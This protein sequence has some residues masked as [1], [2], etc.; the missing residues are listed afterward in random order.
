MK[1]LFPLLLLLL[2]PPAAAGTVTCNLTLGAETVEGPCLYTPRKNGS[3]TA[4]MADGRSLGGAASVTLDLSGPSPRLSGKAADGS[5]R[6]WGIARR[7][8][9]DRACWVGADV[10]LCARA[11]E[12]AAQATDD[13]PVRFTGR[14]HMD[15][16]TWLRQSR[17]WPVAEGSAAVP[18]H[19]VA[20]ME[21][22][23][24]TEHRGADYPDTAPATARWD[25]PHEVRY[26]CSN[27]RPAVQFPDQ[28]WQV[29][30]LPQVFGATEAATAAYL[31]ACHRDAAGGDP[32]EAPA[33]LGYTAGQGSADSYPDFA[34]LIRK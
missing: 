19:A 14:C 2:A 13:L 33:R 25:Q 34:A 11:A 10:R 29:L 6:D 9:G 16:C 30:P 3:F 18:G 17:P 27:Q 21:S 26:F 5:I 12:D 22:M 4:R 1:R 32:Y 20:V 15:S 7:D 8:P 24:V 31:H 28:P 23:A